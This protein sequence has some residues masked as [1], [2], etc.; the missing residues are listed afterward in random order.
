MKRAFGMCDGLQLIFIKLVSV[1]IRRALAR[2]KD[3]AP[4]SMAQAIENEGTGKSH[5]P[6]PFRKRPRDGR[7]RT[8]I[9]QSSRKSFCHVAAGVIAGRC[10]LLNGHARAL[11][12][13]QITCAV[14]RS[15]CYTFEFEDAMGSM[16]T[17]ES[18]ELDKTPW[19]FFPFA[20]MLRGSRNARAGCFFPWRASLLGSATGPI[21][22]KHGET[23]GTQKTLDSR[24]AGTHSAWIIRY[25]AGSGGVP[26]NHHALGWPRYHLPHRYRQAAFHGRL[27]R[28]HV[29]QNG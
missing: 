17:C 20:V 19:I 15:G 24:P 11:R 18:P 5:L 16:G 13:I 10:A 23:Y 1:R 14:I 12:A 9:N 29:H 7:F 4:F 21:L 27:R 22:S 2:H 25:V 3:V 28:D 6:V 26:G 8:L